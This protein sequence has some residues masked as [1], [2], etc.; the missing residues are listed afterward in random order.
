MLDERERM[1]PSSGTDRVDRV[2]DS[3]GFDQ[4]AATY[5]Q[6]V[7]AWEQFPFLG[8]RQVLSGIFRI[9]NVSPGMLV[10]DLGTGT[11]NLARLFL[12][13][14]CQVWATDFSQPMLEKAQE[15]LPN[16]HTALADLC[17]ALPSGFPERYDRIVSSY[18]FHHLILDEKAALVQDLARDRLAPGGAI[19]IG[20]VSF[21]RALDRDDAWRQFAGLWDPNEY[22]WSADEFIGR[23]DVSLHCTYEQVSLCA[24]LY[25]VQPA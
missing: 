1:E 22:Y 24:G 20:D 16:L 3:T 12:E 18:A 5:D 25:T 8:Y 15:K 23:L 21:E 10:L 14:D 6:A 4:W 7:S 19:V 9:A 2:K 11:G 17:D 13:A